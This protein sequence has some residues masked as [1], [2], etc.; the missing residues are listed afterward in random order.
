MVSSLIAASKNVVV[1]LPGQEP[2]ICITKQAD[3]D[4]VK[5][6]MSLLAKPV[7]GASAA[8]SASSASVA[9]ANAVFTSRSPSKRAN[10]F[11]NVKNLV[12]YSFSPD[13]VYTFDFY[14]HVLNIGQMKLDL[15][16][17]SLDVSSIIGF[18]P[19]QVMAVQWDPFNE[20]SDLETVDYFYNIEMWNYK[21]F[22]DHFFGKEEEEKVT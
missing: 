10:F 21:S 19:V 7:G 8:S 20:P 4:A 17:T 18:C 16:F 15:G 5:E 13:H 9:A 3:M 12:K 22:P 6:D 1:S 2:D 14:Q 11:S